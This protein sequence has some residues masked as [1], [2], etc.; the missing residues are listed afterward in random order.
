LAENRSLHLNAS[1]IRNH[2]YSDIIEIRTLSPHI[3]WK[4]T[5]GIHYVHSL[6]IYW[7]VTHFVVV[8]CKLPLS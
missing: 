4:V 8:M 2:L 1:V 5:S 6:P 7:R 3:W